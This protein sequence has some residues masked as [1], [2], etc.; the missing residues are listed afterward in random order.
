MSF[1]LAVRDQLTR[2]SIESNVCQRPVAV[3]ASPPKRLSEIVIRQ[4]S[5]ASSFIRIGT[6][7]AALHAAISHANARNRAV[8]RGGTVRRIVRRGDRDEENDQD[9]GTVDRG[10]AAVCLNDSNR[11]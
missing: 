10:G 4:K 5:H 11:A 6:G 1:A 7:P 8:R 9:G 2:H 3:T